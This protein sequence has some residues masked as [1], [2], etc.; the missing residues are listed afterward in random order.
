MTR[1]SRQRP[2]DLRFT[3]NDYLEN[4]SVKGYLEW[5]RRL[6]LGGPGS[7]RHS[8]GIRPRGRGQRSQRWSCGSLQEAWQQY[9]WKVNTRHDFNYN[10]GILDGLQRDLR[11]ALRDTEESDALKAC[12]EVQKWGGTEKNIPA[13]ERLSAKETLLSYL[14]QCKVAFA[15]ADETGRLNRPNSFRSNAG[16]TKIYSLLCNG[17]VIYDS[18]VAAALG[19]LIVDWCGGQPVPLPDV[20]A[21]LRFRWKVGKEDEN[22]QAPKNRNP[23]RGPYKLSQ[24]HTTGPH[25]VSN[26]WANWLLG[27][28][29]PTGS[30]WGLTDPADKL[31]ALEAA[32]FM[33][34][35][36]L[37]RG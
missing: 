10:K 9:E 1:F 11:D 4:S 26:V 13:L 37:P 21:G 20:P 2:I 15:A 14:P 8:Y 6:V 22:A 23:S 12:I 32:L 30:L 25:A 29:I 7:L 28:A 3:K 34:G 16:F 19:K 17:F 24:W 33:I 35:Y 18:R 36:D 31:R 5:F 27:A